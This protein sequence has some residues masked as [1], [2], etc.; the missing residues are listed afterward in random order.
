MSNTDM[1]TAK[2]LGLT[3]DN[4]YWRRIGKVEIKLD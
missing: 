4:K 2:E 3:W 1:V